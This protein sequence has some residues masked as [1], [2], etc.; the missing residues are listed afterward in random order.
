MPAKP[1]GQRFPQ[2]R[3]SVFHS[4][5]NEIPQYFQKFSLCRRRKAPVADPFASYG[6]SDRAG[7]RTL[8]SRRPFAALPG[9]PVPIVRA[10]L[11]F[12]DAFR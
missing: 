6:G 1:A 11:Q 3:A 8:P 5:L 7:R 10:G 4:Q 2:R 9:D 12:P